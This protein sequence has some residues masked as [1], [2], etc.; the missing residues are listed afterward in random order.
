MMETLE[1][2][3]DLPERLAAALREGRGGAA[4]RIRMSP[5]LSYGRHAGPAPHTARRAAVVVLLF[6][7][8]GQWH[9]PL[10]ERP[11]TLTRHG[12]QISLPGGAI[13]PGESS[14]QTALRELAEELGIA[15]N[16]N[17]L[18]RLADCYIY[19][20]DFLVTPW[21]AA[22]TDDPLWT[23]H[24][25]EVQSIIELP[26][27]LLLDENSIGCTTITR[28]PLV[29][30]APCINIGD[31]CVWGATSVILGELAETLHAVSRK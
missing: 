1:M 22:T 2:A 5:E 21:V 26:L 23:P 19:A 28:G 12:G 7:R 6:R 15:A 30:R 16:V 29:F 20:S 25:R 31:A 24:D 11:A 9:V 3:A 8:G 27:D 4:A 18:G 17:L 14:E 10:T 13:D